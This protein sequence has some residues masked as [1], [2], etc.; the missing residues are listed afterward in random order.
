MHFY[1]SCSLALDLYKVS[2]VHRN[3]FLFP[4]EIELRRPQTCEPRPSSVRC[5]EQPKLLC[6]RTHLKR[7]VKWVLL[8]SSNFSGRRTMRPQTPSG[9][10]EK[11]KLKIIIMAE[12]FHKTLVAIGHFL[13]IKIALWEIA[14]QIAISEWMTIC[15]WT[16]KIY[17]QNKRHF[18]YTIPLFN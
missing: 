9:E 6:P 4:V 2:S 3:S 15:K 8:T 14:L 16:P 18:D 17:K 1:Y 10:G 5:F 12:H 13:S 11:E 7:K